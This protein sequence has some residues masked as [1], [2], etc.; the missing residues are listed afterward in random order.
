MRFCAIL[1]KTGVDIKFGSSKEIPNLEKTGGFAKHQSEN[2]S[3]RPL[4]VMNVEKGPSHY[5]RLMMERMT[6]AQISAE[7]AGIDFKDFKAEM[8]A[9]FIFLHELG[10]GYD[11]LKNVPDPEKH[12]KR[13]EQELNGL[14]VKGWDPASLAKGLEYGGALDQWW[15]DNEIALQRIGYASRRDLL[16]A[17]ERAYHSISSE[18]FPDQFAA[19]IIKK[20]FQ[21]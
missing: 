14:P 10:H 21:K 13:R 5:Q 6:S 4:V 12:K 3:N 18:D 11:Y 2:L 19:K 7:K 20:N 1:K 8:L 15:M 16:D 17:Q 9:A